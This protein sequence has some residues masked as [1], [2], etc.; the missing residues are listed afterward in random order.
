M[1]KE[2]YCYH[3]KASWIKRNI[4]G[5]ALECPD[6]SAGGGIFRDCLTTTLGSFAK[7]LGVSY[8]FH[9]EITG[10]MIVVEI[11]TLVG[12]INSGWKRIMSW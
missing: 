1:I 9:T 8:A 11:H 6:M 10:V 12:G 4:D 7:H 2:I 3:P 5:I